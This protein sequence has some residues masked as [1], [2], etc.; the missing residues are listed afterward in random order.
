MD[1]S[2]QT[3]KVDCTTNAVWTVKIVV[4]GGMVQD[5]ENLPEGWDYEIWDWDV[6]VPC[7][8]CEQPV[9]KE[10]AEPGAPLCFDCM[11]EQLHPS[12]KEEAA[13][14]C[15]SWRFYPY[16][17]MI[18][19]DGPKLQSGVF[20]KVI[21]GRAFDDEGL[22]ITEFCAHMDA[23]RKGFVVWFSRR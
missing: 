23:I 12:M 20:W 6:C 19:E 11:L 1:T 14:T 17:W 5:V 2:E 9:S 18:G 15:T 7:D 8:E 22:R 13:R 10:T 21:I 3:T 16:K 4:E